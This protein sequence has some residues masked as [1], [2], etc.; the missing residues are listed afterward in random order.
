MKDQPPTSTNGLAPF[1]D[2]FVADEAKSSKAKKKARPEPRL[3]WRTDQVCY[4]LSISRRVWERMRASGV[5]PPPDLH[6]SSR[7]PAWR[8]ITI[9]RWLKAKLEQHR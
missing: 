1:L 9:K 3:L 7:I 2:R 8:P 4:V 6:I 5:A